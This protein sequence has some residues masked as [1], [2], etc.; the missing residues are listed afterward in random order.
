MRLRTTGSGAPGWRRATNADSGRCCGRRARCAR[1]ARRRRGCDR[2][3]DRPRPARGGRHV[4]SAG[5]RIRGASMRARNA[6]GCVRRMRSSRMASRRKP[7]TA[8]ATSSSSVSGIR[9]AYLV[10]KRCCGVQRRRATLDRRDHSPGTPPP[11]AAPA[12]RADPDGGRAAGGRL[13]RSLLGRDHRWRL[14]ASGTRDGGR[15]RRPADRTSL[16][17]GPAAPPCRSAKLRRGRARRRHR[18]GRPDSSHRD[19]PPSPPPR[20]ASRSPST[21]S[22]RMG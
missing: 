21:M 15:S 5:A 1:H 13:R 12:P 19:G 20:I 9:R 8:S 11:D 6:R 17:D 2:F 22:T 14:C 7:S 10:R 16:P 3:P 18:H 4:A